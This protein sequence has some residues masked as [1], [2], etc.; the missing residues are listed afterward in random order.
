MAAAVVFSMFPWLSFPLELIFHQI[1]QD[2]PANRA[3]KAMSRI[4]AEVVSC[5]ASANRAEETTFPF[6]HRRSVGI[7]IW[8]ILVARL[9]GK[10]MSLPVGVV[11]LL[12]RGLAVLRLLW[13]LLVVVRRL[14]AAGEGRVSKSAVMGIN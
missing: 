6:A 12:G 8:G 11:D 13:V 7:I 2:S 4:L 1:A 9:G 14:P 5:H 10:L 3:E